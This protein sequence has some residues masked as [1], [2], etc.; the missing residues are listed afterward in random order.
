MNRNKPHQ[1]EE[2]KKYAAF[3]RNDIQNLN[4]FI[5]YLFAPFMFPRIIISWSGLAL[6]SL[7]LTIVSCFNKKGESYTGIKAEIIRL[8]NKYSAQNL[9]YC[10]SCFNIEVE[11]RKIDYSKYLGPDWE[12]SFNNATT[13]VAN[14]QS[15]VD[16]MVHMYR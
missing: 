3:V 1:I 2:D 13:V 7:I 12:C 6:C 16:I 5:L 9:I 4:R 10:M 15:W 14:H 11:L 8:A